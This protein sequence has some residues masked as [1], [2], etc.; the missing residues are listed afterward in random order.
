MKHRELSVK[1]LAEE[2]GVCTDT[3]RRAYRNGFIPGYRV[4]TALR[5]DARKVHAQMRRNT[6]RH[7]QG[8][9][10]RVLDGASRPRA[11]ADRPR[12]G[13]TTR[14]RYPHRRLQE[15]YGIERVSLH[16]DD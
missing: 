3:I 5:F 6:L 14:G 1:E 9:T 13:N 4:G 16:F 8:Q 11:A 15:V 10:G 2:L 7:V 12:T